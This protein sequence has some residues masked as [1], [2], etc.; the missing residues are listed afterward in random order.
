M[1]ARRNPNHFNPEEPGKAL[2][3][4]PESNV[5][6]KVEAPKVVQVAKPVEVKVETKPATIVE[7]VI[8]KV[9]KKK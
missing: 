7:K 6:V 1:I 8:T 4:G 9:T 3:F 5:A 2:E